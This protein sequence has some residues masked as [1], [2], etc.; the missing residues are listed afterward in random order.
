LKPLVTVKE[1]QQEFEKITPPALAWKGD[2]VGLQVG[3][4]SE[5]ITNIL[6]CL[7]VTMEVAHEAKKKNANLII[8]HHPLLFNPIKT[9][10]PKTRVGALLLF[11]IENNI[12]LYAAHTNLDS[13]KWGVNFVLANTLGIKNPEILSPVKE[14]LTKIVVFVPEGYVEKVS[15]AMHE[16]GAG[17]FTKYDM[18]SFRTDGTGTF[19]GMKNAHPFLGEVGKLERAEETR[20]EMLCETWKIDRVLSAMMKAHPYEEVAYDIYPLLNSNTE[21]GLGAI[22]NLHSPVKEKEFLTVV[23]KVLKTT[24]LRYAKG[25]GTVR[26]IAVCG[27]SGSELIAMALDRGADAFVTA[28]VKYHTFQEYENKILLIDAGHYETERLVLPALAQQLSAI[29]KK[30]KNKITIFRTKHDT[31]PIQYYS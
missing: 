18:C 30:K 4:E 12:N 31:N 3:R 9:I 13:V 29:V 6:L 5:R 19:R 17:M 1:F 20:L 10:S 22:G 24:S 8:S 16:A 23:R 26:R 21:Y 7:D 25:S 27:G 28:D 14:H 2:N 15:A 11:L